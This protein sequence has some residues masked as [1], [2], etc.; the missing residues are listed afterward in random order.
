MSFVYSW[1]RGVL[2]YLGLV[3]LEAKMVFLGLDNAGKTTLLGQLAN[4]RLQSHKPTAKAQNEE[5]TL[6]KLT[7]N[8]FDLGG[9][10]PA[11]KQWKKHYIETDVIV[12]MVDSADRAR[13]P[14][15]KKELDDLLKDPV[16]AHVP[17]LV[18]GNKIDDPKAV[19]EQEL[20]NALGLQV[21]TQKG[22][23][24]LEPHIRP[25]EVFMCS[26][27]KGIGYAEGFRWAS[28]YVQGK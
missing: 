4:G 21:T 7:F 26:V 3:N 28:Q 16:I 27:V 23:V 18:L 8:T 12:F 15:A 6:G 22:N 25:I 24:K 17:F 11:R 5:L 19:S 2:S 13:F 20:R 10:K 1:F 9:H 14:E